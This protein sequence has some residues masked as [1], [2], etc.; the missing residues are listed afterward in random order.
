KFTEATIDNY[1]RRE[2]R[3]TYT[4][5]NVT[6]D[7]TP[8]QMQAFV[9]GIRAIILANPYTRKD[10][11]EVHMSG[12]GASSLDVM[13]YFFFRVPSWSE[14]L[15]QRH[16]VFLEIMRLARDLNVGFAFP[17]QTLHLESVAEP[18][19]ERKPAAP[20]PEPRMAEVVQAFA[21]GGQLARPGGPKITDGYL[22]GTQPKERNSRS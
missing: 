17:T 2:Y 10:Y 16:N 6:H 22:A 9:E 11:F 14:E 13:V 15:R 12:F 1:G 3:R 7:T 21:P 4:T 18:G 5:L 20:P 19:A 8:E